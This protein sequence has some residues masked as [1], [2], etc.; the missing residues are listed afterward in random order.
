MAGHVG[1]AQ[2]GTSHTS[3]QSAASC[4]TRTHCMQGAHSNS[5]YG[6]ALKNSTRRCRSSS[7]ASGGGGGG[8]ALNLLPSAPRRGCPRARSC[9]ASFAQKRN[10]MDA[11]EK[12][13]Y[14]ATSSIASTGGNT[15]GVPLATR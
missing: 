2:T 1:H 6:P 7:A 13:G 4:A 14:V 15:S 8:A 12:S 5:S 3:Q 9:F 10:E 11:I